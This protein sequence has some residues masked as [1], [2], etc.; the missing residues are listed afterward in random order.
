LR[1]CLLGF[2]DMFLEI[3][4]KIEKRERIC[5]LTLLIEYPTITHWHIHN[6][7]K[8]KFLRVV[9]NNSKFCLDV[10]NIWYKIIIF[11]KNFGDIKL[12]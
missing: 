2:D 1:I 7:F 3:Y 12:F 11:Y 6:F 4:K 9:S 10:N 5:L 8:K